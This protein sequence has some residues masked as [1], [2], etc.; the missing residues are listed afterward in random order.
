MITK[1]EEYRKIFESGGAVQSAAVM[2][3][4]DGRALILQ[5]GDT[6]PWMPG[7]WNLPGG[8]QDPGESIT[9][10]AIRECNEET[11]LTPYDLSPVLSEGMDGWMVHI[12][13]S[14]RFQGVLALCD[15]SKDHAWIGRGDV[16]NYEYVP[17]VREALLKVLR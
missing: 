13:S 1:I 7:A 6:A 2:L 8:T 10:C 16:D 11:G 17:F 5:R 15:E 14:D 3:V 12:Y 4:R 9:E